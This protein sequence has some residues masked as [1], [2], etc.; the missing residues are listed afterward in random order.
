MLSNPLPGSTM[1]VQQVSHAYGNITCL[2]W[3]SNVWFFTI[4][5]MC[6]KNDVIR[7]GISPRLRQLSAGSQL[8]KCA[9]AKC[10]TVYACACHGLSQDLDRGCPN[11]GF[12]NFWVSK[13]WYKVHTTNETNNIHLQMLL[14]YASNCFVWIIIGVTLHNMHYLLKLSSSANPALNF[15]VFKLSENSVL[16]VQMTRWTHRWLRLAL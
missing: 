10:K 14:F 15:W 16:G 12:I 6:W 5:K 1:D 4:V 3:V 7:S 2:A 9:R 11:E 13:V 8:Y